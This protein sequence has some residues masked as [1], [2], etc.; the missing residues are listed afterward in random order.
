MI[1]LTIGTHEP[2]D[3]LVRAVDAWA[4]ETGAEVFAQITDR[5]EFV[6]Q[7]MTYVNH[8]DPAE[9]D[10]RCAAAPFLIAHAGMGSILAALKLAKPIVVLPRRGHLN[11]TRNDHQFATAQK[12]GTRP[13]I[14]VAET[15][16]DLPQRLSQAQALVAAGTGAAG[17][18][19]PT[20]EPRLIAA[21]RAVILS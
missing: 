8:V 12:F 10:A 18:I 20:A 19:S 3:R 9:Y 5:A 21:I 16:A 11:E 7:H 15:E 13:G 6:P 4:G 1:F 2:F 14:L 17:P